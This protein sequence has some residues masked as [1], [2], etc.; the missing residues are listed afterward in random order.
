MKKLFFPLLALNVF[1]S[2]CSNV[3]EDIN[4]DMQKKFETEMSASLDPVVST[5]S[6][7]SGARMQRKG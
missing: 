3:V 2:S 6:R 7:H 1:I 5:I 4:K